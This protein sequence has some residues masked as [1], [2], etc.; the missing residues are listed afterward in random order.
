MFLLA[1][2]IFLQST[3]LEI[4]SC[5]PA[6]FIRVKGLATCGTTLPTSTESPVPTSPEM[7]QLD[8]GLGPCLQPTKAVF[9]LMYD[10]RSP[11]LCVRASPGNLLK[12]SF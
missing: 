12:C 10:I 11:T 4:L 1:K 6:P 7:S 8:Q 9:K 5:P 2:H 3:F